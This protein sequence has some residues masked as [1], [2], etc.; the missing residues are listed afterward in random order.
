MLESLRKSVAVPQISLL[1]VA[2]AVTALTFGWLLTRD[3]VH[4]LAVYM[5]Q[6][7]LSF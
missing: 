1:P 6:L 4:P 3:L 7:Y 5:L 2:T